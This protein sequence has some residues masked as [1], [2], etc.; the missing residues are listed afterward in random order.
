MVFSARGGWELED[1]YEASSSIGGG[2]SSVV[3]SRHFRE[4]HDDPLDPEWED[5]FAEQ[6]RD[7]R[8]RREDDPTV[9]P[10]F[11]SEWSD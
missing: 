10:I 7:R 9:D 6:E 2:A 4:D 8:E 11:S 1:G 5:W 3:S